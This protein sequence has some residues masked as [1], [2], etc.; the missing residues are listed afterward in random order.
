MW[1]FR[2]Y[3]TIEIGDKKYR[4]PLATQKEIEIWYFKLYGNYTYDDIQNEYGLT[5]N[6]AK[7]AVSKVQW[8]VEELKRLKAN[9]GTSGMYFLTNEETD[10]VKVMNVLHFL[11]KK[12]AQNTNSN[13]LVA[14]R[15]SPEELLKMLELLK[16]DF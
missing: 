6:M 7:Q 4:R 14:Y 16:V 2:K 15:F 5:Y 11:E 9:E 8:A 10:S 13:K 3:T 12:E 1:P